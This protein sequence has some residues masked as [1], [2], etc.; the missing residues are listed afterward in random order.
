MGYRRGTAYQIVFSIG[1]LISFVVA[2]MFY[3]QLGSHLDLFV[4]YPSVTNES[5]MVYYSVEQ[6]FNLDKA[7]MLEWRLS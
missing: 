5:K 6:A 3:Q 2:R 1:Y 4:P 7:F